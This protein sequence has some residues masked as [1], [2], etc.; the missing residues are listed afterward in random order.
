MSRVIHFALVLFAYT[1]LQ[2]WPATAQ[3]LIAT[4][5]ARLSS[6]DHFNSSGAR[7]RNAAAIIRQDRANFHRFGVRDPQDQWDG[8]FA[9]KAN[10]ARLERMLNRGSSTRKVRSRIVNGT[11]VIRVEIYGYGNR[12]SHIEVWVQ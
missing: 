10:R 7:L 11:P 8:F 9:S 4:Y 5:T 1:L 12:G 3:E 6:Q 2:S